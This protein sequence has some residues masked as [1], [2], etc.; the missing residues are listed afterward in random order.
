MS[1]T[2]DE[3][4]TI[5]AVEGGQITKPADHSPTQRDVDSGSDTGEKPVRERLEKTTIAKPQVATGQATGEANN[6]AMDVALGSDVADVP[7]VEDGGKRLAKK[8]S[9]EEVVPEDTTDRSQSPPTPSLGGHARKRSRDVQPGERAKGHRPRSPE[10]TVMEDGEDAAAPPRSNGAGEDL[11]IC[12]VDMETPPS[13]NRGHANGPLQSPRRKR[14]RDEFDSELHRDQKI[15]ATEE[16]RARRSS[17]EERPSARDLDDA[18][19]EATGQS[20]QNGEPIVITEP[21]QNG[22]VSSPSATKV[23]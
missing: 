13:P 10:P 12:P 7:L 9:L 21:V 6:D 3:Q 8:R 18:V 11:K 23:S 2:K 22:N 17:D 1:S 15:V 5:Q 19:L 14:S 4:S 20:K 16:S